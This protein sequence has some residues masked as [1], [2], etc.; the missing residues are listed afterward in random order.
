MKGDTMK[1]I[2]FACDDDQGLNAQMSAHFGRCPYY[3]LVEVNGSEIEGVN[4]IKNPYFN[5][6]VPG[7]VPVFIKDQNA[8]V[9]IAGGMG[10]RAIDLFSGFGIEVATGI[11]GRVEDILKAYLQGAV[12][13]TVACAH[14]H[15]E[16][17]GG[18]H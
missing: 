10:P 14:D 1:I 11:A 5:N 6:H 7:Q 18:G 17:C 13:G 8:N 15:E 12:K 9:M 3:T 2:C 4:V 16:S